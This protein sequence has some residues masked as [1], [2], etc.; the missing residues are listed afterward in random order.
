MLDFPF[1]HILR[2]CGVRGGWAACPKNPA[3]PAQR[4][5]RVCQIIS[6]I[7]AISA[8]VRGMALRHSGFARIAPNLFPQSC[9][10]RTG[11]ADARRAVRASV[12]MPSFSVHRQRPEPKPPSVRLP[13][14]RPRP[15]VQQAT[16]EATNPPV[17]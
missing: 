6:R 5:D 16:A 14:H 3:N 15:I 8:D 1:L 12:A 2:V 9:A 4:G 7:S 11:F 13:F 10:M 17:R